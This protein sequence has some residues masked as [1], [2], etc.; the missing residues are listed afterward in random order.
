MKL[1]VVSPGQ[2]ALTTWSPSA[3]P[4]SS[5]YPA[6]S[7]SSAYSVGEV[8]REP[9]GTESPSARY[10]APSG[11]SPAGDDAAGDADDSPSPE[12]DAVPTTQVAA[13]RPTVSRRNRAVKDVRTRPCYQEVEGAAADCRTRR[14]CSPRSSRPDRHV[15]VA[16]T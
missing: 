9:N 6:K 11:A 16:G 4:T 1:A 14:S 12:Q 3:V 10:V 2:D 15:G 8:F 5:G 13:T 7:A